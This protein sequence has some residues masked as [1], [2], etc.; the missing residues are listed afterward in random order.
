M[1]SE[2]VLAL[3]RKYPQ[4]SKPDGI[5]CL[6]EIDI[7]FH[8]ND[9]YVGLVGIYNRTGIYTRPEVIQFIEEE[10]LNGLIPVLY[11]FEIEVEEIARGRGI[12][13]TLMKCAHEIGISLELYK[14][15]L[16]V[17]KSNI[18]ALEFYLK[19]GYPWIFSLTIVMS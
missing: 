13:R 17:F 5:P 12:G 7:S 15:M 14:I 9:T 2:E 1:W 8:V 10:S 18:A 6:A 11:I 16:T 3:G 19:L 4:F